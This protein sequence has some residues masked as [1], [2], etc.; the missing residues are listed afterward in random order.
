[1]NNRLINTKVAGG[2][3]G[4][5]DI[6]DNYDPFGGN[7]LALYQL[8]GDATDE[9]GNYNGTASNVTWGTGVFGQAG[10]F[11]GSSSSINVPY[12]A[13]GNITVS[14]WVKLNQINSPQPFVCLDNLGAATPTRALQLG[15]SN[16]N[17]IYNYW[18]T[19][20]DITG[21]TALSTGIWYNIVSTFEQGVVAKIYLN[22]QFEGQ[23]TDVGTRPVQP[24][25]FI[26]KY[27]IG[28]IN[29]N[30][31]GSIDQVRI[32]NTALDP[33][34]IEALYTEELC[35]CDGT[36]DTL[37]ILGDGSCIATYQL[38][39]NA[40]DLSGNYSGTPTNVSYGVG[41]FDLAGVFNGSSSAIS[42]PLNTTNIVSNIN[43]I[44][45]NFSFSLWM[46]PEAYGSSNVVFSINA[47][48]PTYQYIGLVMTAT[49]VNFVHYP[50]GAAGNGVGT[51]TDLNVW[52][53]ITCVR[54]NSY[55]KLYK[56][57]TYIGQDLITTGNSTIPT[58]KFWAIGYRPTLND[59]YF[60]G[61]IDQ[62]RIFNKALSAGEV[63]TLYNE[64]AC[65]VTPPTYSTYSAYLNG[66]D[67]YITRTPSAASNR[68]IFTINFWF[69]T[70]QTTR[71]F[72]INQGNDGNDFFAI[73]INNGKINC[74]GYDGG[75]TI[76]LG[77]IDSYNDA[78]WHNYQIAIDT[79]QAT[80]T[81][82]AKVYIDGVQITSFST[83]G[84][85]VVYP[86]LN[87]SFQF[88]TTKTLQIGRLVNS[89]ALY[90]NGYIS[91][92]NVVDGQQLTADS[93]I[94][95]DA[96]K[97]IPKE[98]TGSYGTNGFFL[99]FSDA[100]ELGTDISGNSNNFTESNMD[101]SNQHNNFYV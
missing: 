52:T 82:R 72:V 22:G 93:F 64:T 67:E 7:G 6:V 27:G 2:G 55:L 38:D 97:W 66:L 1:M 19:G 43:D 5:T 99:D 34:E 48:H 80:S 57:G 98:Y 10:V 100:D 45:Q 60:T 36:V 4:C 88:N 70:S 86:S 87:Y 54:E 84:N 28:N 14:A 95:Y 31:N 62:V 32:F 56:N 63:T 51:T 50:G 37:D 58:D 96:P 91:S 77:T 101:S 21:T 92:M 68:Q 12:S 8:N 85:G 30:L 9:S 74:G 79:T 16:T 18:F 59:L 53:Q 29:Y 78:K 42:T 15:L 71:G 13:G 65:T 76:V 94:E 41:E 17:T 44:T 25:F 24:N 23:S 47:G 46:K 83:G 90:Y 49:G 81:N 69:N 20:S 26:G 3:G 73:E 75:N 11:N 61:S 89:N 35:I 39:G 33:L 40:N